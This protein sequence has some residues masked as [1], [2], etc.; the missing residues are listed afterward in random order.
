MSDK[1]F[2][3]VPGKADMNSGRFQLS[4]ERLL[5]LLYLLYCKDTSNAL[6]WPF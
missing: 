6:V 3:K 2:V 4:T 5:E 1:Q